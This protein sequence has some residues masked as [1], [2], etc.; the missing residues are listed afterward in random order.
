MRKKMREGRVPKVDVDIVNRMF[1]LRISGE[2][3]AKIASEAEHISIS[4]NQLVINIL[5]EYFRTKTDK[6]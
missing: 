6:K 2:L 5:D 1:P 4:M 3:H